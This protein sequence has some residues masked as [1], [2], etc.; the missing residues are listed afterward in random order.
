MD[1]D[2]LLVLPELVVAAE[3]DLDKDLR[4]VVDIVADKRLQNSAK[5]RFRIVRS[6]LAPESYRHRLLWFVNGKN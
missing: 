6:W 1:L 3:L 4:C 2:D 5:A